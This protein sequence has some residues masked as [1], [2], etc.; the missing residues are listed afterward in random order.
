VSSQFRRLRL[1]PGTDPVEQPPDQAEKQRMHLDAPTTFGGVHPGQVL[2]GTTRGVG[3]T[4]PITDVFV[5]KTAIC[6]LVHRERR[7]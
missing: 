2:A 3:S 6:M 4:L 5:Q 7:A 1:A